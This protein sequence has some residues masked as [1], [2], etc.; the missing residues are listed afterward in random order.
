M[1]HPSCATVRRPRASPS[2]STTTTMIIHSNITPA[3]TQKP[4]N[5]N[6]VVITAGETI[7]CEKN[8]TSTTITTTGSVTTAQID[9]LLIN[10]DTFDDF[11]GGSNGYSDGGFEDEIQITQN[12][13]DD[14]NSFINYA[15]L[16][17]GI[18]HL[19]SSIQL[20]RHY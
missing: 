1:K 19:I 11:G 8:A 4:S 16:I 3:N 12:N 5:P 20:S 17:Q 18:F 9:A 10:H 15:I 6:K 13:I 14:P 7:V 2:S